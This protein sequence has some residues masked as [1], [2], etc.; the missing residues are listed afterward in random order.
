MSERSQLIDWIR[1]E[2]VGPSRPITDVTI[3]EF[4]GRD[5]HD[6]RATESVRVACDKRSQ[7][8]LASWLS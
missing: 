6:L 7:R 4:R 1:S 5:F 8:V 2:I 3:I